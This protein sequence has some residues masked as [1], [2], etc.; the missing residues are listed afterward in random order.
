M[1][2]LIFAGLLALSPITAYADAGI[3]GSWEAD[4][5]GNVTIA[6]DVTPD[7][8]WSSQTVN[9]KSV[10]A[11]MSGTYTQTKKNGASGKLVFT[12]TKEKVAAGQHAPTVETD[13]YSLKNG[14][15]V[16]TLDSAGDVM[17]FN[18]Q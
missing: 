5:G 18:K 3:A 1:R 10:V 15:K 13:D 7:G 8:H 12:P 2:A 11:E 6:M 16:L 17:V 9:G 4:L 14:G